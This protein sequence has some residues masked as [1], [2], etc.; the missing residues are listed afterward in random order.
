MQQSIMIYDTKH[1]RIKNTKQYKRVLRKTNWVATNF[2][3]LEPKK[4]YLTII[5]SKNKAKVFVVRNM[6]NVI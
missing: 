3:L 4:M 2:N 6:W 1:N 5:D